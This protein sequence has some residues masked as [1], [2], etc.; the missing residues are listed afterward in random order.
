[1]NE[2]N[3]EQRMMRAAKL[4]AMCKIGYLDPEQYITTVNLCEQLENA[5]LCVAIEC[6]RL[7]VVKQLVEQG[8]NIYLNNQ[9][10]L[11][12]AM[13][14]GRDT[15]IAFFIAHAEELMKKWLKEKPNGI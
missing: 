10:A 8:A 11:H 7:D 2:V 5:A 15:I 1:M 9:R 12:V 13:I 14:E 4:L 3:L 6:D